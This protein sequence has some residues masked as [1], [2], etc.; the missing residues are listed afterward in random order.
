M[1]MEF[2]SDYGADPDDEKPGVQR[3]DC[4]VARYD[5]ETHIY[6]FPRDLSWQARGMVKLHVEEGTLHPY[7]GL[8]LMSI[9][10]RLESG[11]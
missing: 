11:S 3:L 4:L 1:V 7:A 6:R 5:G 9:I 10:R 2:A 8:V